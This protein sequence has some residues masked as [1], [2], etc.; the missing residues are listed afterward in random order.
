MNKIITLPCPWCGC[1][2]INISVSEICCP[3][4]Y[5][6]I[7]RCNDCY[8]ECPDGSGVV[9]SIEEANILAIEAWNSREV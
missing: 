4:Q 2:K 6:A 9:N 1:N 8:A 3:I 7:A 5:S